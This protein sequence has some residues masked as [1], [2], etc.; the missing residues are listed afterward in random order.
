M[1][2]GVIFN[3]AWHLMVFAL[4][5]ADECVIGTETRSCHFTKLLTFLCSYLLSDSDCGA[6]MTT[7][8]DHNAW[9]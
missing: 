7:E 4:I 1:V 9:H 3:V 2:K 5:S 8:L 6:C